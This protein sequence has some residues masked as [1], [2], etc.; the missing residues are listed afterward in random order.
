ML[1]AIGR[2]MQMCAAPRRELPRRPPPAPLVCRRWRQTI[3]IPTKPDRISFVSWLGRV[4]EIN[5]QEWRPVGTAALVAFSGLVA[6][7]TYL[8][9]AGER[10]VYIL[11][12]ANLA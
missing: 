4:T 11:D 10:W 12:S 1:C 7:I 2:R 9:H 6:L 3:L 8:A 5:A